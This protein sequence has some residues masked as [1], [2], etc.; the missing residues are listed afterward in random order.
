MV[1]FLPLSF[2]PCHTNTPQSPVPVQGHQCQSSFLGSHAHVLTNI[3]E[4]ERRGISKTALWSLK[5]GQAASG[6][7]NDW[8][9]E[10]R[11]VPWSVTASKQWEVA[12]GSVFG[13]VEEM[14]HPCGH[15]A[16]WPA[17][18]NWLSWTPG[19]SWAHVSNPAEHKAVLGVLAKGHD[20][21]PVEIRWRFV[22]NSSCSRAVPYIVTTIIS[23]LLHMDFSK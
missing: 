23:G 9:A 14:Q 1:P 7:C 15:W 21:G 10:F 22:I 4:A 12:A 19:Y 2:S 5:V 13:P 16:I 11:S 3:M 8:A 18:L 6:H 17:S 20:P